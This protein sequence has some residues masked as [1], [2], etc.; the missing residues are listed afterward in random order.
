MGLAEEMEEIAALARPHAGEGEQLAA[1]IAAE[2]SAGLRVYLCGFVDGEARSWLALRADGSPVSDRA[3]LLE[4]VSIAALCE[5]ADEITGRLDDAP[6][7]ATPAYLEAA[8]MA[9][10]GDAPS[11]AQAMKHGATAVE[12]LTAEV[13]SAYKIELG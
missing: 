4:A 2:P 12:G 10:S 8:A 6:R 3:L 11:F 13:E 5:L 9:A 7:V 1:V